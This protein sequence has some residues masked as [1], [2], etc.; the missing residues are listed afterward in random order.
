M[1]ESL[2]RTLRRYI[3]RVGW[4]TLKEL[5]ER[6]KKGFLSSLWTGRNF[7]KGLIKDN[8]LTQKQS[9]DI[10]GASNNVVI[11]FNL[12]AT[13]FDRIARTPQLQ[14]EIAQTVGIE[15]KIRLSHILAD[16]YDQAGAPEAQDFLRSIP[17]GNQITT[18]F[19]KPSEGDGFNVHI[20]LPQQFRELV[21]PHIPRHGYDDRFDKS[22]LANRL[23]DKLSQHLS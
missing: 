5:H 15:T 20:P 21:T 23:L 18:S 11:K 22:L 9:A 2:N 7:A 1:I 6:Q 8:E 4:D 12:T 16:I 13:N 14:E 17:K 3:E 10:S 19:T